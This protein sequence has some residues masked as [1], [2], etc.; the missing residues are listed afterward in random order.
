MRQ[1]C[2]DVLSCG[3][4]PLAY[5][6]R[7]NNSTSTRKSQGIISIIGVSPSALFKASHRESQAGIYKRT[8]LRC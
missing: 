2:N 6:S 3:G 7:G 4:A 5:F 1:K 8:N